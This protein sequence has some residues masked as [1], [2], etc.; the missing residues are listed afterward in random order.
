MDDFRNCGSI[1]LTLTIAQ[2]GQHSGSTEPPTEEIG[3]EAITGLFAQ[4][5]VIPEVGSYVFEVYGRGTRLDRAPSQKACRKAKPLEVVVDREI[6][7]RLFN[8]VAA[9][10]EGMLSEPARDG[11][12]HGDGM[13]GGSTLG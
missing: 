3:S 5:E 7:Q 8:I 4:G 12:M 2:D 13:H 10:Q 11:G 1:I 6:G 9:A